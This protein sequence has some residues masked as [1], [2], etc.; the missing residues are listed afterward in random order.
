MK[1]LPKLTLSQ[2]RQKGGWDLRH[3]KT[4]KLVHHFKRKENA[5]RGGVMKGMLGGEGGSVRIEKEK[6]G[7]QEERTYPRKR[8]PR[9]SPG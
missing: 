1:K 5:T 3:N 2:N 9:S 4:R 8:D 6:G 7:F